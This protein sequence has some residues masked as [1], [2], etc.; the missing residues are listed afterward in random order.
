MS[1]YFFW[2]KLSRRFLDENVDH[3]NIS[4]ISLNQTKN[5]KFLIKAR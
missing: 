1:V 5:H 2:C 3:G 4:S